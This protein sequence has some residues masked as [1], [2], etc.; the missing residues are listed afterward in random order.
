L[1]RVCVTLRVI[2]ITK[3]CMI[4]DV[5]VFD[6]RSAELQAR[7]QAVSAQE[8]AMQEQQQ[9]QDKAQ[10]AAVSQLSAQ[11]AQ[12]QEV[13]ARRDAALLLAQ[14]QL[15]GEQQKVCESADKS[16][17]LQEALAAAEAKAA[18]LEQAAANQ[19][20]LVSRQKRLEAAEADVQEQR[21]L[22]RAN[23]DI[24]EAR[25]QQ[26]RRK[27]AAAA[28]AAEQLSM[29]RPRLEGAGLGRAGDACSE[30]L[31]AAA[32]GGGVGGGPK[33]V[34]LTIHVKPAAGMVYRIG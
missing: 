31:S 9:L 32:G 26:L 4:C 22:L 19:G 10:A 2:K 34:R 33:V 23:L 25:E 5:S 14:Q 12:L 3:S 15:R 24:L 27:Q 16:K 30:L 1:L 17:V 29:L 28:A 13:L 21:A 7:Q 8:A 11:V 20:S 6:R 18:E